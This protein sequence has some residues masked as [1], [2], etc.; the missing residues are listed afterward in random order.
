[1]ILRAYISRR[2]QCHSNVSA[3]VTEESTQRGLCNWNRL[4]WG[5][6]MATARLSVVRPAPIGAST[7]ESTSAERVVLMC[8]SAL[9]TGL[10]QQQC[11]EIASYA[12]ARTF[13]RD[14]L[15]F[16][17]GQQ[18]RSILLLQSGSVKLTQLSSSGNEVILWMN[19]SGDA[20]GVHSESQACNHSCSARALEQRSEEH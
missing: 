15:L 10:T 1:M 11:M 3:H 19:G 2:F 16:M 7:T 14:E 18:V 13:A 6:F 5:R 12:R 17:Q 9:F 8:A 4:S 20:V